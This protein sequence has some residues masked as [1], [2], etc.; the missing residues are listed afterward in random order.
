MWTVNTLKTKLFVN[1]DI[2]MIYA[3]DSSL[4]GFYFQKRIW[5][6]IVAFPN[7]SVEVWTKDI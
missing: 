2:M 6:V 3:R 4:H 7:S 5:Q 1:D